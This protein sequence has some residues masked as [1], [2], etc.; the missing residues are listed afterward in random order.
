MPTVTVRPIQ[1]ISVRVNQ[2]NQQ[3][4]HST[5]TFIGAADVRSQVNTAIQLAQSA[6][7]TANTKVSKA[8]D[9]MTGNLIVTAPAEVIAI[10]DGGTFS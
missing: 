2:Q 1:Q 6:Y 10:I 5:A 8:G 9:T 7:D 4:V 3:T